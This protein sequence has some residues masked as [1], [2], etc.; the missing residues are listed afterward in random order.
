MAKIFAH[1]FDKDPLL[2]IN[3][4]HPHACLSASVNLIIQMYPHVFMR[5]CVCQSDI[6]SVRPSVRKRNRWKNDKHYLLCCKISP[7]SH[8]IHISGNPLKE[9][10]AICVLAT[11][12]KQA[13]KH[14]ISELLQIQIIPRGKSMRYGQKERIKEESDI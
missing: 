3:S 1:R 5:W 11:A 10:R 9:N 12:N 6:S 8:P 7:P 13:S 2:S 14:T 4:R